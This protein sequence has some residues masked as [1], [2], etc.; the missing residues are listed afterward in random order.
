MKKSA[1]AGLLPVG[2]TDVLPPFASSEADAVERIIHTFQNYAY[3]RVSPP[4][5]EFEETLFF[6][7]NDDLKNQTFRLVD[8]LSGKTM[9]IRADMTD[10]IAR[11]ALTRLADEPRPLRLAYAGHVLRLK[12]TQLNPARQILQVGAELIGTDSA[13]ADAEVVL[14]AVKALKSIGIENVSID[15]NL[16]TLFPALCRA[17]GFDSETAE[18]LSVLIN[19]KD[20]SAAGAFLESL[21]AVGRKALSLFNVLFEAYGD[22]GRVVSLLNTL[23]LPEEARAECHRLAQVADK[24]KASGTSLKITADALENRGFEYHCGIAFTLYDADTFVELGRG[25]R[26]IASVTGKSGEPA[27]GVTLLMTEILSVLKIPAAQKR[28]YVPVGTP[29]SETEKLKEYAVVC[30]LSN[31]AKGEA[32]RLSCDFIYSDGV[33][34]PL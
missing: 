22:C 1:A 26:Y 3:Q 19:Q 32:R 4:M 2:M 15:L 28:V 13:Q 23:A 33:V 6:R 31:D 29:F 7:Q 8:A 14:L 11:I 16:P 24:L 17:Y 34:R 5:A 18:S 30:G 21:G 25:G 20:F 12:G 27:V 9:G 10:Q